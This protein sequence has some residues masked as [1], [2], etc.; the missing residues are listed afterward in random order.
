MV[1]RAALESELAAPTP[2][3]ATPLSLMALVAPGQHVCVCVHMCVCRGVGVSQ[4]APLP[5]S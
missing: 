4:V 1:Q 3:P 5:E 2:D